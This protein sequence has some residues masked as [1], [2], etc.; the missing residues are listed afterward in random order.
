M[1]WLS[2]AIPGAIPKTGPQ[3]YS[4]KSRI[5]P[6]Y[7]QDHSGLGAPQHV[8]AHP[9]STPSAS[10]SEQISGLV[11]KLPT[12]GW[13]ATSSYNKL[14]ADCGKKTSWAVAGHLLQEAN[15]R[16]VSDLI[17]YNSVLAL[18]QWIW[19]L[20]LLG[21]MHQIQM[22]LDLV[23]FNASITSTTSTERWEAALHF[24]SVAK[25]RELQPN[26]V[27][28]NSLIMTCTR[29][30]MWKHAT[31]IWESL[32]ENRLEP[33]SK[34][35]TCAVNI[36]EAAATWFE[37]LQLLKE[38]QLSNIIHVATHTAAISVCG[39]CGDWQAALFLLN[40]MESLRIQPNVI[41]INAAIDA[42]AIGNQWLAAIEL[43]RSGM[44][45]MQ[46]DCTTY[47][48]LICACEWNDALWLLGEAHSKTLGM[49]LVTQNSCISAVREE[50]KRSLCL[51]HDVLEMS[52][53][54]SLNSLNAAIVACARGDWPQSLQLL[55]EM[56]SEETE[57]TEETSGDGTRTSRT[58]GIRNRRKRRRGKLFAHLKPD[59]T[60]FTSVLMSCNDGDW[61]L[62]FHLMSEFQQYFKPGVVSY[63]S[64]MNACAKGSQWGQ[65]L[66]LLNRMDS[67]SEEKTGELDLRFPLVPNEKSFKIAIHAC[68]LS[69][70]WQEA[71]LVLEKA[72]A[73]VKVETRINKMRYAA[74]FFFWD[75]ERGF[76]RAPY[77]TQTFYSSVVI[78]LQ[79]LV[80][81]IWFILALKASMKKMVTQ[82]LYSM[83]LEG[84][85][86]WYLAM[87]FEWFGHF[88][89]FL[90]VLGNLKE[91][92]KKVEPNWTVTWAVDPSKLSQAGG[93]QVVPWHEQA[94]TFGSPNC[95]P[96]HSTKA[97]V[98]V[99]SCLAWRLFFA[100]ISLVNTCEHMSNI[101]YISMLFY[102]DI[103]DLNVILYVPSWSSKRIL[104]FATFDLPRLQKGPR[105]SDSKKTSRRRSEL[106]QRIQRFWC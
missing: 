100:S 8:M 89:S 56:G 17:T 55:D 24:A 90:S 70:K 57:E 84:S 19:S 93:V 101:Q 52:L 10:A 34:S 39:K 11:R 46:W 28:S 2:F 26:I 83:V 80:S 66:A 20:Q 77:A 91:K 31:D 61:Q 103:L 86:P 49:D 65:V 97:P 6:R 85:H 78:M 64:L 74:L 59:A 79:I 1:C 21:Q 87:S 51:L 88:G 45:G 72:A 69:K 27:T 44:S 96:S 9:S 35:Y 105:R 16:R 63:N 18:K 98:R 60:S 38:A 58:E 81:Q 73:S 12:H 33:T 36:C 92:R 14:I 68:N 99:W 95:H 94:R 32:S 42:C 25:V 47:A 5:F 23:S 29:A 71:L 37:A 7:S 106:F 82:T 40:N 22:Q 67:G 3:L 15:Q 76:L 48:S 13:L 104:D 43:I 53:E 54:P 75:V 30:Q 4:F 41:T 102:V 62:A 50:W